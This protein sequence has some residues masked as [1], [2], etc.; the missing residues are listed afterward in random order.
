MGTWASD[1]FGNDGACDYRATVIDL[2]LKTFKQPGDFFDIDEVMAAGAMI[3]AICDRCGVPGGL[4]DF[5]FDNLQTSVLRVYDAEID[6]Y[7]RN[8]DYK[9]DRR[10]VIV[11]TFDD[12]KAHINAEKTA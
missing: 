5:D 10:E 9:R 2:L 7:S 8:T 1:N 6:N 11:Q 3:L 12:L 4:L